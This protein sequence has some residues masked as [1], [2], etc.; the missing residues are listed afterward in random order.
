VKQSETVIRMNVQRASLDDCT[1]SSEAPK[2]GKH[3]DFALD[4]IYMSH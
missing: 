1:L 4:S 3:A 2:G